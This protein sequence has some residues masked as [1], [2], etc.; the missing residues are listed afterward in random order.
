MKRIRV[1]DVT[2]RDGGC[3]NNFNFSQNNMKMIM[4]AQEEAGIDI[5]ELGY[6]DEKNGSEIGRTQYVNETVIQKTIL[7]RK[8]SGITYVAM[9]DYGKYDISRLKK[10]TVSSIDG[11]RM[12][13]HKKNRFD[14]IRLGRAIIEKGYQFYVQPMV[15]LRYS[16]SELLELIELVNSE[17]PDAS[18][19]YIVDSFGEMRPNDMSRIINLVDHNLISNIP[20]GFH[21]HN[22]LQLSYS[23]AMTMLQFPSTR[24]FI[25]DCSIMGMGKGAGNLNT[26]L[27]LEHLNLYYGKEY[28]V[29]PLLEVIDSVINQIH[30]EFYWGYAPEYYLS[31]ANHCTPSYASYFYNKHMLPIDKV[32]ELLGMIDEDKKISFDKEY[33]DKLYYK[34]NAINYDD[35]NT[36]LALKRIIGE[37]CVLLIAPGPSICKY[38]DKIR[39]LIVCDDLV[40]ISINNIPP[41]EVDL[42]FASKTSALDK[43]KSTNAKIVTT[44]NVSMDDKYMVVNY[45]S[46]TDGPDGK[47]DAA[48]IIVG[49]I[50]KNI[51]VKRVMLAGFDGFK[52]DSEK[53]YYDE[54][55]R[56]PMTRQDV[57]ERNHKTETYLKRLNEE[58]IIEF[59]TPS[60]YKLKV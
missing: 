48:M 37:K 12:A 25:L 33:A 23:N 1:L 57:N 7:E 43:A 47:S 50:L 39:K 42:T 6:I 49:N 20:I 31:S 29:A 59:V 35:T 51:G 22:N 10:R 34:Y 19:F 44:S 52:T 46:W 14:M 15:T 9:V 8:K 26:E 36:I 28:K 30:D 54:S 38:L 41:F 58:M 21:S 32:G 55:L 56:R 18:G 2:L 4:N 5:I 17:L 16:D 53:N 11:I 60:D 40:T 27:L 45:D 13:F 24:E 3:V